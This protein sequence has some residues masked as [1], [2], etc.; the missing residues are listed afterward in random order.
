MIS[1]A[2]LSSIVDH[3][4]HLGYLAAM[5]D[6]CPCLAKGAPRLVVSNSHR[7]LSASQ[8]PK[9]D[10]ICRYSHLWRAAT[11]LLYDYAAAADLGCFPE[12]EN[13]SHEPALGQSFG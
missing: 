9:I 12:Q 5:L 8:G 10:E 3:W 6:D 1:V 4:R 7:K 13:A 11:W 2:G